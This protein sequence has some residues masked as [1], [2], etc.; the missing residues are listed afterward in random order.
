MDTLSSYVED[1]GA[2]D[3]HDAEALVFAVTIGCLQWFDN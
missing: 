3:N 2:N 1:D